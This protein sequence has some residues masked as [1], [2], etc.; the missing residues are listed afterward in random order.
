MVQQTT[1]LLSGGSYSFLISGRRTVMSHS[2]VPLACYKCHQDGAPSPWTP[3]WK[4]C[5][6]PA[7]AETDTCLAAT[8]GYLIRDDHRT[9]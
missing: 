4:P 5:A 7:G 3:A 8:R 9:T 2:W 1:S 6:V